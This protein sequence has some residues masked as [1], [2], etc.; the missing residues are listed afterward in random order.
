[1]IKSNL[2]RPCSGLAGLSNGFSS[3][4]SVEVRSNC[5]G[6]WSAVD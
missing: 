1:M 2:D 6:S 5:D 4:E 3:G